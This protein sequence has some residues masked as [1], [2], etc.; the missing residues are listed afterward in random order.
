MAEGYHDAAGEWRE[1]PASTLDAVLG[2]MG[3]SGESPPPRSALA[4]ARPGGS[5]GVDGPVELV[6]EDG[7][8]L[9]LGP[10]QPVPPD[11]PF[12]YHR[13]TD[14]D[15]GGDHLMVVGPG[16]CPLPAARTWGWAVQLYAAR[17]TASWG[18]GDLGDLAQLGRWSAGDLGAGFLLVNPLHAAVPV[19]PQ[20]ASPYYPSSRRFRNPLYL[21]V[22]DVPGA[23]TLGPALDDLSAAGRRLNADRRV[24]RNEVFRLK[25]A[26][27]AEL[28]ERFPGDPAF[29]RWCTAQGDALENYATFCVLTERHGR[30]WRDWPGGVRHPEGP[31]VAAFRRVHRRRVDFHRWLQWLVDRQLATASTE[32][33]VVQDL[34]VGF[35]PGGADAWEWQDVVAPGMSV[36]APPDEFN[37]KGQ[38]WGLPPFDPWHLRAAGYRPFVETVRAALSHAGGLRL[39][40]VMGLFRLFWVPAGCPAAD[41]TYVRYPAA[42]LLEVVALESHRAG[43]W[44]VGEDLG[45]VEDHVRDELATRNVLSYRLL[46]FEPGDPAGFPER[47]LAAVTTHDLPTVAGLWSGAD[48]DAQR[49]LD[50]APNEEGTAAIRERIAAVA[51]VGDDAPVDRVVEGVH[52]ALARA[53]SVLLT[54]ALDD[55]LAVEERP[56]MPGTVDEWPN[57][58]I[59]LPATVDD[60][61]AHPGPAALAAI[62]GSGRAGARPAVEAARSRESIGDGDAG[63]GPG[64]VAPAG[65]GLA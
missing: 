1:P 33:A 4:A 50:M 51:G 9:R 32:V 44:V 13:L 61:V 26:A 38:D 34:A 24:D 10:G 36:G 28:W 56:N 46:W 64:P 12:G 14:L 58:S 27:L 54:A 30:P 37:T 17:S 16:A 59:A 22:E 6:T 18:I 47:A 49:R 20:D 55:A 65:H 29:D 62:L 19:L 5:T 3:A 39:D 45:T 57:W 60:I 48:L 41:G 8:T 31:A 7:A 11:L 2:A 40:H 43:A 15:G 52:R 53:P 35:D 42:D 63:S 21:R 23:A 25:S